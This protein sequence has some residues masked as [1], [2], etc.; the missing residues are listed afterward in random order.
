[1]DVVDQGSV[2]RWQ[3]WRKIEAKHRMKEGDCELV[4]HIFSR[5]MFSP[6][7]L[8]QASVFASQ[9]T[10]KDNQIFSFQKQDLL[11]FSSFKVE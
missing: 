9:F 4:R 8:L 10:P 3:R 6:R 5:S 2:G 11:S 7:R 1:M